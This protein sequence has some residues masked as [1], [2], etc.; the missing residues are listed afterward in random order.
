MNIFTTPVAMVGALVAVPLVLSVVGTWL[1]RRWATRGGFVDRPGGHKGH[2]AAVPLGGGIAILAAI[3]LPLWGGLALATVLAWVQ[4]D[5]LPEAFRIHLPGVMARLPR[6]ALITAGAL[7]LHLVGLYDDRRPLSARTKLLAQVLVAVG[8]VGLAGVRAFEF[9]GA[10][11]AGVLTVLW[12]VGITNVL[13]FLDNTD[14]LCAGVVVIA[15]AI[16]AVSAMLA[17]QLFVPALTWMVV[18]AA[19]GFLLHNFPPARVFMGDAG[20]LVLGYFLAVLT[21]LTTFYDPQQGLKPYAV[22]MPLMVLAIPL[23]D[24]ASVMWIRWGE[25]RPLWHGDRR[26]FSH[27]LVERGMSPA[28]AV[29]TIYLA[30]AATG[31]SAMLLSR[32]SWFQAVLL[33]WQTVLVVLIIALLERGGLRN[34]QAPP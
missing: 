25:G 24:T 7:V 5:W 34:G 23:Y 17:G 6:V 3:L 31:L 19:G 29:L 8:L 32:A 14:G 27:R 16:F 30:T 26:H 15:G 28:G 11:P 22:L 21:V 33:G 13:N 2:P 12:L 9:L 4:P 1:V 18:G 20:S 10:W